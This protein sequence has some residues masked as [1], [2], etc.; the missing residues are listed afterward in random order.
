M[1]RIRSK[2]M[3]SLLV[4][5]L[6][7]LIPSYHLVSG[8]VDRSFDIALNENV[9]GAIAGATSMSRQLT[10]GTATKRCAWPALWRRLP[11]FMLC[12]MPAVPRRRWKAFERKRRSWVNTR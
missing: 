11:A 7:P 9:A 5:T 6:I 3:L 8:M 1:R 2:L 12:C 4:V 10:S